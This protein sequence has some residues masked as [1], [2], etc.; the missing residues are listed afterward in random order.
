MRRPWDRFR[1]LPVRIALLV[2]LALAVLLPAGLRLERILSDR[3]IESRIADLQA[4]LGSRI[5]AMEIQIALADTQ[6]TRLVHLISTA[7]DRVDQRDAADFDRATR[8]EPD[9]RTR[10]VRSID[11][12]TEAVMSVP[13]NH[14]LDWFWKGF[15]GRTWAIVG[16]FGAGTFGVTAHDVSFITPTGAE[17]IYIPEDPDYAE[18]PEGATYDASTWI[19]PVR[20]ENNPS[21]RPIWLPVQRQPLPPIWFATVEAPVFHRGVLLGAAGLD[22]SIGGLFGQADKFPAGPGNAYLLI[23]KGLIIQAGGAEFGRALTDSVT[24]G[25]LPSVLRDSIGVLIERTRSAGPGQQVSGSPGSRILLARRVVSRDRTVIT[26]V[27]RAAVVAPLQA[28]LRLMRV[29]LI[30]VFGLLL[31]AILAAVATD[32]RR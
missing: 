24:V 22:F 2:G 9:G 1:T 6:V 10:P 4:S 26:L 30:S 5:A 32:F 7:A 18:R 16:Q 8:R 27:E 3:L 13:S 19:N 28:P 23:E 12:A 14:P 20:P 25:D 11:P 21:G 29:A 15:L 31:I 17:I